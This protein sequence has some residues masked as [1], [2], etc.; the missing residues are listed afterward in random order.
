[1]YKNL[2]FS[3]TLYLK[4]VLINTLLSQFYTKF[5]FAFI[6]QAKN[7]ILAIVKFSND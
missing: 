7:L 4:S 2:N 5:L 6:F 1:M 3:L